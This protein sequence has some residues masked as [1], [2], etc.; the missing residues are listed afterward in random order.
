[1]RQ[2]TQTKLSV[3]TDSALCSDTY[4]SNEILVLKQDPAFCENFESVNIKKF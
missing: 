4:I 1:M 3:S 2:K